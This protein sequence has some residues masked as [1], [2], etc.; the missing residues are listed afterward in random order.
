MHGADTVLLLAMVQNSGR[1]EIPNGT[2]TV[3]TRFIHGEVQ[4]LLQH[5]ILLVTRLISISHRQLRSHLPPR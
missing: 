2:D 5:K 1:S 3:Q 4:I